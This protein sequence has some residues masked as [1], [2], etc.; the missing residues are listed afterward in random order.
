MELNMNKHAE[1]IAAL[2]RKAES[3]NSPEEAATFAEAAE[4]LMLKYSV[5]QAMLD[6]AGGEKLADIHTWRFEL[7]H[8]S[9]HARRLQVFLIGPLVRA[10][11][12]CRIFVSGPKVV[13]LVGRPD[14][15][16]ANRILIESLMAQCLGQMRAWSAT[17]WRFA[18][19]DRA[20]KRN[21]QGQF[22]ASFGMTVAARVE[23]LYQETVAET[24]GSELA[25]ANRLA[26][27]DAFVAANMK[28]GQA[29][30]TRLKGSAMGRQE[31]TL[32]G[33]RANIGNSVGSSS[34]RPAIR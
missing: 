24:T 16:E 1:R 5:D 3:T 26:D 13:F 31:G 28:T 4:R 15:I 11:G 6:A 18:G 30:Q 27:V 12:T 21:A 19:L 10:I 8:T 34:S 17:D 25:L 14:D 7:H 9:A 22:I 23:R 2:L 29:K 20:E 32:A 33:Q